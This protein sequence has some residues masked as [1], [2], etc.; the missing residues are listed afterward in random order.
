MAVVLETLRAIQAGPLL[1]RDVIVLIDDGEEGGL[2]GAN[3]FVGEH[4]WAKDIGVVL[5][6]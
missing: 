3:L 2:S 1:D 5:E 4:P 6:L